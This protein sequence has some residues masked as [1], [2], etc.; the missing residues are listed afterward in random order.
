MLAVRDNPLWSP[1]RYPLIFLDVV[2]EIAQRDYE[3][4]TEASDSGD[5]IPSDDRA[6]LIAL[7]QQI[8]KARFDQFHRSI[9]RGWPGTP[10]VALF[11]EVIRPNI[12]IR[13]RNVLGMDIV[14]PVVAPG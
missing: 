10:N 4:R 14:I 6:D 5:Q 3:R 11:P 8:D 13:T 7:P 1:D 12:V 9:I 2:R